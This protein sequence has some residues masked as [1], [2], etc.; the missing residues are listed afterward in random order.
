M[1]PAYECPSPSAHYDRAVPA[2]VI[3]DLSI[4]DPAVVAES[5]RW[6]QGRRGVAVGDDDMQGVD[7]SAFVTQALRVGAQAIRGAGDAQDTANIER[8]VTDVGNRTTE[9]TS[10]AMDSATAV[11]HSAAVA[12]QKAS[13][14]ANEAIAEASREARQSF[15][16]SVDSTGKA[17]LAEVNRL[18]GGDEPE[19]AARLMPLL[20]KFGREL[21]TRVIKQ[22]NELLTTAARQFDPSDPTSPM[23]K[24]A[25][26]LKQQQESLAGALEKNHK[27]LAAK[28]EEL[29]TAVKVS[30]AAR[31][32]TAQAA[33]VT[34]L[35]GTTYATGV[36][37]VMEQIAAG[38]GDE[39]ADTGSV[40][41]TISRNKKGDGVLTV[42]GGATR[43]VLEMTDSKRTNWNDYLEEAERNR[44]ASASLG[45]VRERSRNNGSTI[46]SLGSRRIIMAFDPVT[47]D[48]DLLRTVVQ[49]LRISALAASSR[50]DHDEIQTADEKITEAI[51]LLS[52]ID[53][54]KKTAGTL[55]QSAGKIEQQSDD[56]RTALGRL[57][58]QAQAAL[59]FVTTAVDDQAA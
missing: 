18:V 29:A 5:L 14:A 23:A 48:P 31:D 28:V 35:K 8:L 26:E 38:L 19:L 9:T 52:K 56:V 36:H 45:L 59:S 54:I 10:M 21:D 1:N 53:D 57:L 20:E 16:Q 32:A 44:Q 50:Q 40:P 49:V 39:Y 7:L 41:G 22:T 34:P 27:D 51:S 6:S 25:Q 12:M 4:A 58:A 3:R 11:V 24:H 37:A 46:R 33:K 47:D 2:V 13:A 15:A 55:R 43:I 17:L 30:T 42:N